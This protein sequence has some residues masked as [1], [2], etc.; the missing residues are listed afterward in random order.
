MADRKLQRRILE[1]LS[2]AAPQM[3]LDKVL[4]ADVRVAHGATVTKATFDTELQ[5]LE[6]ADGGAQVVGISSEAGTKWKISPEGQARL[7]GA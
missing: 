7:A 5:R 3:M 2:E 4:L 6:D 1:I